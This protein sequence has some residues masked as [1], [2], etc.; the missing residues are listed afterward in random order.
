MAALS[1][2]FDP[3]PFPKTNYLGKWCPGK[4]SNLHALRHGLLRPACLPFHHPGGGCGGSLPPGESGWQAPI[5]GSTR[6]TT[7]ASIA[8][9]GAAANFTAPSG[10]APPDSRSRRES[11]VGESS[12]GSVRRVGLH[13]V[14]VRRRRAGPIGPEDRLAIGGIRLGV[15]VAEQFSLPG[16]RRRDVRQRG[17]QSTH[18]KRRPARRPSVCRYG[19]RPV[20]LGLGMGARLTGFWRARIGT[21]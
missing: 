21:G 20:D 13:A 4:D 7:G 8:C 17:R 9:K 16:V 11:L 14:V 15:V 10:K 12:P 2:Y 3:F 19:P 1:G 18:R 6:G 5:G